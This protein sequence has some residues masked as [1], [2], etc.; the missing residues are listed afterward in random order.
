MSFWNGTFGKESKYTTNSAMIIMVLASTSF[1][2][3]YWCFYFLLKTSISSMKH[4][5]NN[6]AKEL[7]TTRDPFKVSFKDPKYCNTA[8]NPSKPEN[9]SG[10]VTALDSSKPENV[11][12]MVIKLLFAK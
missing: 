5:C 7:Q 3:N 2:E 11:I 12:C 10:N 9:G 4:S 1:S 8:L 6:D